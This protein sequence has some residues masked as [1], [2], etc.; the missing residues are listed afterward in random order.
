M[1]L[2]SVDPARWDVK[3]SK[4]QNATTVLKVESSSSIIIRREMVSILDASVE[5]DHALNTNCGLSGAL[6]YLILSRMLSHHTPISLHIRSLGATAIATSQ[7]VLQN[8]PTSLNV[9]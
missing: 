2:A 4:R 9:S 6:P 8:V 3:T 5:E 7:H 1:L